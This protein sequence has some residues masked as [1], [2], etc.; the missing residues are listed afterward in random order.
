MGIEPTEIGMIDP[1]LRVSE[2]SA[3]PGRGA[4]ATGDFGNGFPP[5]TSGIGKWGSK[6]GLDGSI[7]GSFSITG[8]GTEKILGVR[9]ESGK[10]NFRGEVEICSSGTV[11]SGEIGQECAL[12][13]VKSIGE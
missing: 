2:K 4:P 9:L 10:G 11:P 5:W 6:K 3:Q 13:K 7:G 1:I 12:A 8:E